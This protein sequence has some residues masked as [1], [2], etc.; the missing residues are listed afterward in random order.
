MAKSKKPA[1]KKAAK[2][3]VAA[4]KA[5]AKK[6]KKK[7]AKTARVSLALVKR[8]LKAAEKALNDPILRP[9]PK[10]SGGGV[11]PKGAALLG[12]PDDGTEGDDDGQPIRLWITFCNTEGHPIGAATPDFN[13]AEARTQAHIQST[14]PNHDAQTVSA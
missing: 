5:P 13:K 9:K 3:K 10:R 14:N 4:K 2:K 7:A 8:K 11:P 12:M 1:A 6:V